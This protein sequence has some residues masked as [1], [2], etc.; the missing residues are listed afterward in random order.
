MLSRPKE[1]STIVRPS[2]LSLVSSSDGASVSGLWLSP[3]SN[4]YVLGS[5]LS[6]Q[7]LNT[8]LPAEDQWYFKCQMPCIGLRSGTQREDIQ[9]SWVFLRRSWYLPGVMLS[10]SG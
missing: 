1:H 9:D 5:R 4:R 6:A 3:L 7:T 8:R 10:R 2:T